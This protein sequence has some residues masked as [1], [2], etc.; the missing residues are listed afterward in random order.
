MILF[1][2]IVVHVEFFDIILFD[3]LEDLAKLSMIQVDE[4]HD[5]RSRLKFYFQ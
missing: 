1:F 2:E 5:Q 3:L 4:L